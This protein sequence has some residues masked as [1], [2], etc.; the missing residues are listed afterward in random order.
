M[1]DPAS[2]ISEFDLQ[3]LQAIY[4][5]LRDHGSWPT[6]A[7]VDRV[8]D[9]RLGIED[10]QAVLAQLPSGYLPRSWNRTGYVDND[11]VRL[12]LRG[13][14][15]CAGSVPDLQRLVEFLRWAAE[16]ER[17]YDGDGQATVTGPD[18]AERIGLLIEEIDPEIP[19]EGQIVAEPARGVELAP[20]DEPGATP[21]SAI[22]PEIVEAR[23]TIIRVHVMGDLVPV[24]WTGSGHSNEKPWQWTYTLARGVRQFRTLA[25]VDQLLAIEAELHRAREAA[26][27]FTMGDLQSSSP[28]LTVVPEFDETRTV[29]QEHSESNSLDVFLTLLRP[30]IADAS[31]EQLRHKLYDDAIFAAYRRVEHEIQQ[32]TQFTSIGDTLVKDAFQNANPRITISHRARDGERLGEIFSGVLGLYKGDRSHK[33]KPSLPCRSQRECLRLL[34]QAS[35]LLDLLDRGIEHA[36]C[37]DGYQQ[38]KDDLELSVRRAGPRTQVWL[39]DRPCLVRAR[40]ATTMTVVI[41]GVSAGPHDLYLVDGTH[42]GPAVPI[43]IIREPAQ[44]GWA[45]ITEIDIELFRDDSATRHDDVTGVRLEFIEND[46]R[47]ERIVPT[48]E[49]YEVG[50]YVGAG[51]PGRNVGEVWIRQHGE[52]QLSQLYSGSSTFSGQVVGSA[53]PTRTVRFSIEPTTLRLRRGERAPVR[54]VRHVSDGIVIWPETVDSPSIEPDDITIAYYKNG[55]IYANRDG[56]TELRLHYE[57]HYCSASVEVAAHSV[58]TSTDY[59][60][61]L[62]IVAGVACIRDNLVVSTRTNTL[63]HVDQ[64]KLVPLT[65]IPQSRNMLGGTD[66]IAG[67]PSGDLAVRSTDRR[68]LLILSAADK[69]AGSRILALPNDQQISSMTWNNGDLIVGTPFGEL[70]KSTPA[71]RH[72]HMASVGGH[73]V[74]VTTDLNF[75]Y[76]LTG[77]APR[78]LIRLSLAD[79][80]STEDLFPPGRIGDASAVQ[81]LGDQVYLT[82]FHAGQLLLIDG[83]DLRTVMK[84]L[85]NPC[86]IASDSLGNVT[87]QVVPSCLC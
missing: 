57:G 73:I 51:R 26:Q 74:S 75:V 20:T 8:L 85:S 53:Q 63:W 4:D 77:P 60:T 83:S 48:S 16:K 9:R 81:C 65:A 61:G 33:D 36:P 50:N 76:V 12:T 72:Q 64:G 68:D 40:T 44:Q 55:V 22:A 5:H 59:L 17:N 10:A 39:D 56:L 35:A 11:E 13:I 24:F 80:G 67:S 38:R 14:A 62:P 47:R 23:N 87:I 28:G 54:V 25:N 1:N 30:E 43:F 37:V 86:A 70:W 27:T 7:Q 45:R 82:E 18:F 46:I 19:D 41:T 52:S 66:L 69:Y 29:I 49:R 42:Q 71:G 3:V 31:T 79:S 34:A 2:R 58:G 32:R 21:V 78:R 6:F 84:G 15:A